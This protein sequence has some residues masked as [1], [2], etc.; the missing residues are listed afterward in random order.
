MMRGKEFGDFDVRLIISKPN[1]A[2]TEGCPLHSVCDPR[3]QVENSGDLLCVVV[4]VEVG[5]TS[6][7]VRH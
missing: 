4:D 5:V 7:P 2:G 6:E 3:R 1:R